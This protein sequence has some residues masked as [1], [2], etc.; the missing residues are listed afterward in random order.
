M[1]IRCHLMNSAA[2]A[3]LGSRRPLFFR[4]INELLEGLVIS[5]I[6]EQMPGSVGSGNVSQS[7]TKQDWM[8]RFK[9]NYGSSTYVSSMLYYCNITYFLLLLILTIMI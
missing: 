6:S 8:R 1:Q 7:S 2:V 4:I 3:G 5:I 9:D